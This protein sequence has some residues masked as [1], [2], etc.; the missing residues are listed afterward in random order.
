MRP[1]IALALLV[2]LAAHATAGVT[3]HETD[4]AP[5]LT[6]RAREVSALEL[7]REVAR[8]TNRVLLTTEDLPAGDL[9]SAVDLRDRAVDEI[10]EILAGAAG[11]AATIKMDSITV[12]TEP[13]DL[14][15][16]ELRLRALSAH[17]RALLAH[18]HHDEMLRTRVEMARLHL[19]LGQEESAIDE[20][21]RASEAIANLPPGGQDEDVLELARSIAVLLGEG[22]ARLGK[23]EHVVRHHAALATDPD[24]DA[25]IRVRLGRAYL[26]LGRNGEARDQLVLACHAEAPHGVEAE[27]ALGQLDMATGDPL[28]AL[29][30]LR[31]AT[32]SPDAR[33]GGTALLALAGLHREGEDP[34]AE[35]ETLVVF[36]RRYPD[37]ERAAGAML[38]LV[39][40]TEGPL[41][42]PLDAAL[43]LEETLKKHPGCMDELAAILR[44]AKLRARA[45]LVDSACASLESEIEAR[46]DDDPARAAL[47]EE[48]GEILEDALLPARARIA[49]RRLSLVRGRDLSARLRAAR[50]L[51]SIA[52][53]AAS[54]AEQRRELLSCLEEIRSVP[55]ANLEGELRALRLDLEVR[56][57]ELL[58]DHEGALKVIE[59]A[60]R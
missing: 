3:V 25:G 11:L 58:G 50:C 19:G 26:A 34:R 14:T 53:E 48:L 24:C 47:L 35:A 4:G 36:G 52:V 31:R 30:H 5:R 21:L 41:A 28:A 56:C 44:L 23:W 12:T 16:R 45:E 8:R 57:L 38:R 37:D 42:R 46:T 7:L 59:E 18:P 15:P 54:A 10:V 29:D 9:L 1:A 32:S 22:Y 6:V 33:I 49:Y 60:V 17:A 2:A 55:L 51:L 20:L 27:L 13:A 40:L 39:A 43:L